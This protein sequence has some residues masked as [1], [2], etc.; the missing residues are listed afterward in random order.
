MHHCSSGLIST[1]WL[2]ISTYHCG[3]P[4]KMVKCF[5]TFWISGQMPIAEA[6][7]KKFLSG[8][9]RDEGVAQLS[10]G[11]NKDIGIYEL[12]LPIFVI[13]HLPHAA[14]L[15]KCCTL[16]SCLGHNILGDAIPVA[17]VLEILFD[18]WTICKVVLPIGI[19]IRRE[20]ISDG[21]RIT[22]HSWQD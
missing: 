16:H 8:N 1:L 7:L 20:G 6:P 12:H 14:V 18:L 3:V 15:I 2:G 10:H 13:F 5:A 4:W 19:G 17:Q 22:A 11:R 9:F 21:W